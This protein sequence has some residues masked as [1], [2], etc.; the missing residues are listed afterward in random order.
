[1]VTSNNL[2][3]CFYLTLAYGVIGFDIIP[4]IPFLFLKIH[5]A[6]T[7]LFLSIQKRRPE[8]RPY[9][10]IKYNVSYFKL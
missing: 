2:A 4:K 6:K 10:T 1:M 5:E 9:W 8:G 7:F 3:V